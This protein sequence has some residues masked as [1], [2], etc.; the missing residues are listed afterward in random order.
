[1]LSQSVVQPYNRNQQVRWDTVIARRPV[2]KTAH[3]GGD[4][5]PAAG[6]IKKKMKVSLDLGQDYAVEKGLPDFF[7]YMPEHQSKDQI[8][9]FM[10]KGA[11]LLI[12]GGIHN[13]IVGVASFVTMKG[14]LFVD[15]IAMSHG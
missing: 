7:I 10:K 13:D 3:Y 6:L 14:G 4:T 9:G 11:A 5:K 1:M 2:R 15:L 12:T 8:L